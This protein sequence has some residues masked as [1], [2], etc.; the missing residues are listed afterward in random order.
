[1]LDFVILT[2]VTPVASITDPL[3]IM[4]LGIA[5]VAAWSRFRYAILIALIGIGG[6]VRL[7]IAQANRAFLELPPHPMP[8]SI[9][10]GTALGIL[11][12]FGLSMLATRIRRP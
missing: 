5:A 2:L 4:L 6:G 10:L 12:V 3:F 7:N 8:A 1:M 11:I 9:V